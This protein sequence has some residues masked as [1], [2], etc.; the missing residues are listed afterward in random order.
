MFCQNLQLIM[1][2]KLKC[3]PQEFVPDT[4]K[5]SG[6]LKLMNSNKGELLRALQYYWTQVVHSLGLGESYTPAHADYAKNTNDS[7]SK[8]SK[9]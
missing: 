5:N 4:M 7:E 6:Y 9:Y 3:S 1:E 8:Y 2:M